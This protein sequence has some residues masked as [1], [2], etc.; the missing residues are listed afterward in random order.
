MSNFIET[1]ESKLVNSDV[2]F[3]EFDKGLWFYL[4]SRTKKELKSLTKQLNAKGKYLSD[5][6]IGNIRL[7]VMSYLK[8]D[9][10]L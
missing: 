9:F 8:I 7:E 6:N 4:C 1:L 3:Q 10:M 2:T 5:C